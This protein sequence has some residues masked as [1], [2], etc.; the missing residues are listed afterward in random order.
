L[1][2]E[3]KI[4]VYFRYEFGVEKKNIYLQEFY[5]EKK[6]RYFFKEFGQKNHEKFFSQFFFPKKVFIILKN[7]VDKFLRKIDSVADRNFF[8]ATWRKTFPKI[9][10]IV[11]TFAEKIFSLCIE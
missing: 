9:P 11:P 4:N 2:I 6:R 8:F 7:L 10:K 3:R 1:S 5:E